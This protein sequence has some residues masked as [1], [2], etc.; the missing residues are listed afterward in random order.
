VA[1]REVA[2]LE[3]SLAGEVARMVVLIH[4]VKVAED[5]ANFERWARPRIGRLII[6]EIDQLLATRARLS[7]T[8]LICSISRLK[9]CLRGLL[10]H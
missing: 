3:H 4:P 2:F 10:V 8:W 5:R 9:A 7:Q 6:E 1:D